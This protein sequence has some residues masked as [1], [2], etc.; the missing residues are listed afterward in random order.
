VN[1][2]P[3]ARSLSR[4]GFRI[5]VWCKLTGIGSIQGRTRDLQEEALEQQTA[6]ADVCF[7]R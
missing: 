7:P 6:T 3:T 2:P 4:L 1:D 5:R